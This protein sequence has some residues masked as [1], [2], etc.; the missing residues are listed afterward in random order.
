MLSNPSL[1]RLYLP[2]RGNNSESEF[3]SALA[4]I[5]VI[6]EKYSATHHIIL[7]GDMNASLLE[8]R[9]S[10]DKKFSKWCNQQ[11]IPISDNYPHVPTHA[12][13]RGSGAST[14][15]YIL[16][17][18]NDLLSTPMVLTEN[19]EKHIITPSCGRHHMH[20]VTRSTCE[21]VSA[22]PPP[23]RAYNWSRCDQEQYCNII[24]YLMPTMDHV[25]THCPEA[26]CE[27]LMHTLHYAASRSIPR[28]KSRKNR[29][30]WDIDVSHAMAANKDTLREW[31]NVRRPSQGISYE[32][33]KHTK[34]CLR[35][36][37]RQA[38]AKSRTK[39]YEDIAESADS[40]N[41][42]LF[43]RFIRKQRATPAVSGGELIIADLVMEAWTIHFENLATPQ[44]HPEYDDSHRDFVEED[45][46]VMEWI[47]CEQSSDGL[48]RPITPGEVICAINSLNSGKAAD[49]FGLKAE[50]MKKAGRVISTFL[51]DLFNAVL[52]LGH[53]L[54]PLN[55]AYI[56]PI[57]NKGKDRL[58]TDNH[59][60]IAIT[61]ILAKTLGHIILSRISPKFLQSP[62]QFGF[63]K[64]L[65]PTMAALAITEAISD[66]CD[67]RTTLYV[68]ALDVRKAFDVVDHRLLLHKLYH[69]S[70]HSSWTYIHGSLNTSAK[71][72]LHGL[73]GDSFS[74]DQGV[75]QG[76]I[77][78]THSYNE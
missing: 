23:P 44:N 68:I 29:Q 42:K 48:E 8:N 25:D 75:G 64:E 21:P 46:L 49:I 56:L 12:H 57:H 63:T 71:V 22:E 65:S 17:S 54:Q 70:D 19:V 69:V 10:R 52:D 76:K 31:L 7:A 2:C 43:H 66:A 18:A 24:S 4:A 67:N 32:D 15:D 33:R 34:K 60:G 20:H 16:S 55:E 35:R 50:H 30:V 13:H 28:P 53:T 37:L 40:K 5:Q 78:S 58:Y 27:T 41:T 26:Y 38:N 39:I 6:M 9:C 47:S 72:K 59:R 62:F 11:N 51:A 14:I 45:L 77:T 36:A 3:S 74:V 73:L 1:S 61:P